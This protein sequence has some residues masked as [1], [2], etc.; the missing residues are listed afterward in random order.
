MIIRNAAMSL[1]ALCVATPALAN[2]QPWFDTQLPTQKRIDLLIDAMTLKEKT[3]QLVNGNVACL[4]YTSD[5]AD[6]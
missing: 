2:D 6:E 3:S 5:A 1:L 4:L